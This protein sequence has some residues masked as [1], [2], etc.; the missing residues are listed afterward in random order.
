MADIDQALTNEETENT[1]TREE[2]SEDAE[3]QK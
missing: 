3:K 2:E 1:E